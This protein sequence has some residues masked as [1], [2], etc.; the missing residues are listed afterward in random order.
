[1]KR[2]ATRIWAAAAALAV[3]AGPVPA[4]AAPPCF[5]PVEIEADQALRYQTELMVLSDT[6]GGADYRDFTVRNREQIVAYQHA[7]K[8]YFR[9]TGARNPDASLD[10]FLTRIANEAALQDGRELRQEVCTRSVTFFATAKTLDREQFRRHASE[11]ATQNQATY[12][13]CK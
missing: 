4:L 13:R 12:R 11:L 5:Q 7:L 3:A 6:C 10:S 9:R 8:D 2:F 1:M